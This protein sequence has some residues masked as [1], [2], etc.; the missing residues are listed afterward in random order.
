M[1]GQWYKS[2]LLIISNVE[3]MNLINY[4]EDSS[5]KGYILK[6]DVKYLEELHELH[7]DIPI[8]FD[9]MKIHK[10][11]KPVIFSKSKTMS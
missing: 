9:I 7:I 5:D 11:E 8:L 10:C 2:C 4:D 1:V 6:V 3:I